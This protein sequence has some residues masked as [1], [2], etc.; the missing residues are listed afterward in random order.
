[1]NTYA[2]AG[3]MVTLIG[4]GGFHGMSQTLKVIRV[5]AKSIS[6]GIDASDAVKYS[7]RSGMN[8]FSQ[9]AEYR[10]PDELIDLKDE[11]YLGP[12]RGWGIVKT[13]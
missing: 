11:V 4:F 10:L 13:A 7:R 12:G 9:F 3:D 8:G 1:M 6:L 5:S 2:K